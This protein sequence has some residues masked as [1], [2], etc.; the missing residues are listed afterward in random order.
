MPELP[1]VET[2][3]RQLAPLLRGRALRRFEVLDPLLNVPN[4]H[5]LLDLRARNVTRDGKQVSLVFCRSG[6]RRTS[7]RLLCHLRMTGRLIWLAD[8]KSVV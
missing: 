8:R 2:V 3:A 6:A 4:R 5:L 1:E 7:C